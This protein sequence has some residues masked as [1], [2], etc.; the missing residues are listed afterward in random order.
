MTMN[1][2]SQANATAQADPVDAIAE[3]HHPDIVVVTETKRYKRPDLKQELHRR[4]TAHH[5]MTSTGNAGVTVLLN[6]HFTTIDAVTLHP[7]P[8]A[9]QGYIL[10]TAHCNLGSAQ[11]FTSLEYTS[12]MMPHTSSTGTRHTTT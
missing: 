5:S 6:R 11:Q 1:I 10:H 8:H 4:D 7:V 3:S 12:P 2:R 9:C